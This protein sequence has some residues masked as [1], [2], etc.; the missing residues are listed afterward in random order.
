MSKEDIGRIALGAPALQQ[1]VLV[2]LPDCLPV[3]QWTRSEGRDSEAVAAHMGSLF[4]QAVDTARASAARG[5]ALAVTIETEDAVLMIRPL[6][7]DAAAG[8]VFD[9]SAPMGLVRMQARQLSGHLA[10]IIPAPRESQDLSATPERQTRDLAP[11]VEGAAET[12]IAPA[13]PSVVPTSTPARAGE[14]PK[15]SSAPR[16]RAVRLLEFFNR[17]AP[18]PHA[19]TLRLSLRTGI[20]VEQLANPEALSEDQVEA[21]AVAVRDILG[22]EQLGF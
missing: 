1:V 8:F 11:H 17:Y 2:S 20:G 10:N 6:G 3:K 13:R 14:A 19:S 15:T 7:P 16:P 21:L 9:R 22:Q 18:D 5:K 12:I 4:G